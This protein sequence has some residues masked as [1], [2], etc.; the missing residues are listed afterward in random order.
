[1]DFTELRKKALD[2]SFSID[3]IPYALDRKGKCQCG[4]RENRPLDMM[5]NGKTMVLVICL[6]CKEVMRPVF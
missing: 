2:G 5:I 4:K 3:E 6:W 1:M